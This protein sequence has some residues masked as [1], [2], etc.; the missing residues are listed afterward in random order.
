[1]ARDFNMPPLPLEALTLNPRHH[2]AALWWLGWLYRNPASFINS[3][4]ELPRWRAFRGGLII[5]L[6]VLPWVVLLAVLSWL[7][8]G[9]AKPLVREGESIFGQGFAAFGYGVVISFYMSI[10]GGLAGGLVAGLVSLL[11]RSYGVGLR[12]IL[13]VSLGVGIAVSFLAD[14]A[15]DRGYYKMWL[16]SFFYFTI[17]F[18][19]VYFRL[20]YQPLHAVFWMLRGSPRFYH[21][22]PAAWD[23]CCLLPFPFLDRLLVC[24]AELDRARMEREIRR[25]IAEVPGQKAAAV[26][27]WTILRARDAARVD[28]LRDISKALADMPEG[29]K[30]YLAETRRIRELAEAIVCQQLRLDATSRPYFREI[31]AR[32]L[33]AEN[34]NFEARV[35]GMHE[36]LASE[37]RRAAGCWLKLAEA[38]AA[39]VS[40]AAEAE[41]A[42]QVF[43]AGDPVA[44]AQEAFVPRFRVLEELEGQVMLGS[45][46]PG[47]LL[48]APR[49][50]GKS[51][52]LKNVSG[53]LPKEVAVAFVSLQSARL[54]SSTG[55]FVGG[56]AEAVA[57]S[58]PEL[59]ELDSVKQSLRSNRPAD[60]AGFLRFL[61]DCNA[62]L[63][64]AG[65]RLVLAL[66]EYEMLD[67]KLREGVFSKDLLA[68]LRES[69]QSHRRIIWAFSGNADITEL[70]GAD[71]TSYLISVRTLEVPLFTP[72]ET[73][74]LLTQPLKHSALREEDKAKSAL[75]WREFWGEDGLARIH[76]ESGGWPYFVQLIA[77]TAVTLANE[78]ASVAKP[79][80]AALLERALDE[81]VSRGRN[82]FHQLLRSQCR[83]GSGEWEYLAEFA[84]GESQPPP[85][86][87]ETRR[88]L[89]R[90]QLL[91][92]TPGSEWRLVV[93]LMARWLRKEG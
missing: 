37:F 74:L 89:K 68:T 63:E 25:M 56:L 30:G 93:P 46:C 87:A 72:E 61:G 52:L 19:L 17:G 81:S 9:L 66:D 42:P 71:W 76:A 41:P 38:Q 14:F 10:A 45:G 92:E 91:T 8:P 50:M 11:A 4:K 82:A 6:Q 55:H 67:E 58:L 39:T 60:L 85:A 34:H 80:P 3:L 2:L 59:A 86:A 31:E 90:R 73:H 15:S 69:I 49:R 77:E 44:V 20:Y 70:T 29:V 35:S 36:P 51:S 75:F 47:V 22:H 1:M 21:Y 64:R 12:R 18:L 5:F 26:R 79:L 33:V 54:F 32:N 78:S 40:A 16:L 23:W 27:A 43:R 24:Y 13:G 62:A 53:F 65:W 28:T 7:F 48:R 83:E 84:R 88:L 57:G